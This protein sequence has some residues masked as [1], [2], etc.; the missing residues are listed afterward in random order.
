[1]PDRSILAGI[2]TIFTAK[3]RRGETPITGGTLCVTRFL[4]WLY[5]GFATLAGVDTNYVDV[6]GIGAEH[7]EL[8]RKLI[9]AKLTVEEVGQ[10]EQLLTLIPVSR[11][12]QCDTRT[13]NHSEPTPP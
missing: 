8:V 10:L 12:A 3:K 2:T 4:Q 5:P 13:Y 1:M 9:K 11:K 6:S 7:R